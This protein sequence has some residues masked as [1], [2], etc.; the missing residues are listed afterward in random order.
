MKTTAK[1]FLII[2]IIF[3][4]LMT[5][6]IFIGLSTSVNE[7]GAIGAIIYGLF[8]LFGSCVGMFALVKLNDAKTA[9]D[10]QATAIVTLLFCNLI[11]GII[12]LCMKDE[13]LQ[14]A[15][16]SPAT[17]GDNNHNRAETSAVKSKKEIYAAGC[18]DFLNA[19]F[20]PNPSLTG[21]IKNPWQYS[22][23][24]IVWFV[25]FNE[26]KNGCEVFMPDRNT[27]IEYC[28]NKEYDSMHP[29]KISFPDCYRLAVETVDFYED[30]KVRKYRIIGL[31]EISKE[32]A[33]P[34]PNVL[35]FDKI[36]DDVAEKI[37]PEAFLDIKTV[38]TKNN[39]QGEKPMIKK[40][41]FANSHAEFINTVFDPFP[42]LKK[43][44]KCVWPCAP[45]TI[46]W[47]IRFD[48]IISDYTNY[49]LDD[50]SIL[51]QYFGHEQE[52]I[53][54]GNVTY[55]DYNRLAVEVIDGDGS[56][57]RKYRIIG[58]YKINWEKTKPYKLFLDKVPDETAA[59]IV[60]EAFN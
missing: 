28:Y 25:R 23:N 35:R 22:Q 56:G 41:I 57:R 47:M 1:V 10:L 6:T 44:M 48:R 26:V 59:K 20:N 3:Q 7:A 38:T 5:I 43:L 12:M 40:E 27:I 54:H 13:N 2:S 32:N 21:L 24:V 45:N 4:I 34:Q 53:N 30:T 52:R 60:P 58:L 8:S 31:F 15:T 11:A 55:P 36:P 17:T 51:E 39:N 33:R 9:K 18:A 46:V 50:G 19:V 14:T 49:L 37:I 29:V 42:P 16:S